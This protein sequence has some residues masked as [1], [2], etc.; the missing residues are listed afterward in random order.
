MD[1]I[2]KIKEEGYTEY[3]ELLLRRDRLRKE[4]HLLQ[5]EY[6]AEFGTLITAIFEKKISCIR[7]K[8]TISFCQTTLNYGTKIDQDAL[9]EYLAQEMQEYEK[10]LTDMI[11]E[12]EAVRNIEYISGETVIKIKRLYHKLAKKIHPDIFPKTN[13]IPELKDLWQMIVV[14]YNANDLEELQDAEVLV[15]KFLSDKGIS[16][17]QIQIHNI[18]EKIEQIRE[19]ILKIKG[20]NPYQYKF[21]L[22]D[23]QCVERKKQEL[24]QT[25]KEYDE[26]EQTLDQVLEQIMADGVSFIW[27]MN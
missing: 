17:E 10:Q 19:Q 7:K 16:D 9:Q 11:R 8:K 1:E 3:E 18:R 15:N 2:I 21:L 12:N 23:K 6:T 26:Y 27:H 13:E 22:R 20:T 24:R 25:F 4:A 14:S 5:K